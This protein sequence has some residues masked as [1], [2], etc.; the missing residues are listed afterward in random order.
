MDR[1]TLITLL[2]SAAIEQLAQAQPAN[3]Y[4]VGV[5][6]EGGSFYAMVDGFK[7]GL[8]RL[9]FEEDKDYVLNALTM[10]DADAYFFAPDGMAASQ[11][12]VHH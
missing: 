2:G 8:K 6:L 7:D 10:Q 4:R 11:A 5:V 9:G 1:R 3:A 12:Q